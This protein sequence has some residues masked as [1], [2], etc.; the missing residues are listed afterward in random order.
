M[1][2]RIICRWKALH[3]ILKDCRQP[4]KSG[5]LLPAFCLLLIM[6]IKVNAKGQEALITTKELK[7]LAE[8]V[9]VAEN[10]ILVSCCCIHIHVS[11]SVV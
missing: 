3:S 4:M 6:P 11:A 7:E 5:L 10:A 1:S 2:N 9:K 8:K